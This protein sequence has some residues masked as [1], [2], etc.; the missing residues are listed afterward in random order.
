MMR[1]V[2]FDLMDPAWQRLVTSQ[3]PIIDSGDREELGSVG[4]HAQRQM[5]VVPLG[6]DL[7]VHGVL[8]ACDRIG[9][10]SE[11]DMDDAH[12]LATLV[13]QLSVSLENGRL[14]DHLAEVRTLK[15]KLEEQVQSKDQLIASV[16]HEL[17][18]PLT[19]V[20]GIAD[21]LQASVEL[22]DPAEVRE[23][24]GMIVSQGRELS[25]IIDDLLVQA[26]AGNGTLKVFPQPI[27]LPSEISAVVATSSVPGTR[28]EEGPGLRPAL[29]DPLRLRQVVRNLLTN[30]VRYGGPVVHVEIGRA[31]AG[32]EVR[33]VDNGEGVPEQ[34]EESIFEP[35]E[36]AHTQT[37]QP[38]SV[39]LGLP[40]SRSIARLMG[41][42][43]TYARRG[44]NTV[45]TLWVPQA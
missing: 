29:V 22:A 2:Q 8:V 24:I 31:N 9:D 42:D 32:F 3:E 38:G 34:H 21:L 25:N 40:V 4:F 20:I 17:R 27:D 33:V 19:G 12:L 15:A 41:G 10:V 18:T 26:K 1:R 5:I 16:S 7:Q 28:I 11:F 35:Y 44:P 23:L 45:F 6:D 37:A 14:T 39:G 30:S 13:S 43:L 36:T